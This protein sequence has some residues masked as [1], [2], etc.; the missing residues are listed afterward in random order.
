M[1]I[2]LCWNEEKLNRKAAKEM[3]TKERAPQEEKMPASFWTTAGILCR[4]KSAQ[5]ATII[6]ILFVT[7]F[8]P[9]RIYIYVCVSVRV[10]TFNCYPCIHNI[11]KLHNRTHTNNVYVSCFDSVQFGSVS[12]RFNS[13]RFRHGYVLSEGQKLHARVFMASN[14]LMFFVIK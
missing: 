3:E 1:N 4:N 2:T 14:K 7:I 13:I 11:Q 10:C 5:L 8:Q 12:I 6:I 9:F